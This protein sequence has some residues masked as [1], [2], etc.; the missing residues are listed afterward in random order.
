MLPAKGYLTT[1]YVPK[2]IVAHKKIRNRKH[3]ISV[4]SKLKLKVKDRV[5]KITVNEQSEIISDD[6][7]DAHTM[8][9]LCILQILWW[10]ENIKE[11]TY[12]R[13]NY[14]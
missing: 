6:D 3:Q 8:N 11:R 2:K 7:N 9:L 14:V 10:V 4:H 1:V 12:Y 5:W 13:S